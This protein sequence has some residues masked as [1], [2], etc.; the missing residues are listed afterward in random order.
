MEP[1]LLQNLWFLLFGVLV[2]G[3]GLTVVALVTGGAHFRRA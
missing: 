3:Y 2:A 1:N